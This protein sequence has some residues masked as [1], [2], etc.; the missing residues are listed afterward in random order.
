MI[1]TRT[2]GDINEPKNNT[3]AKYSMINLHGLFC[4]V[5][6]VRKAI[7]QRRINGVWLSVYVHINVN[8]RNANVALPIP[9]DR[10]LFMFMPGTNAS[11]ARHS[12]LGQ[13]MEMV[14]HIISTPIKIPVTCIAAVVIPAGAGRYLKNRI[15]IMDIAMIHALF[16]ADIFIFSPY[17]ILSRWD[18]CCKS[19]FAQPLGLCKI[20]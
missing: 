20:L 7:A 17:K 11:A 8:I 14:I 2:V 16:S 1:T 4:A 10:M 3:L 13:S 19:N 6:V 9:D 5:F 12:M 18:I 15:K